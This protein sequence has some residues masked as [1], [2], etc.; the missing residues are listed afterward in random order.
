MIN[1]H[2]SNRL[3]CLF[4][5]LCDIIETFPDDPLQPEVIVVQNLGMARWLSQQIALQTGIAA[6]FDFP[7]PASFVWQ[8]FESQVDTPET[9]PVFE[10]PVMLWR[11]LELL[12]VL[13]REQ[14]FDEVAG[15]L[16][17]DRDGRKAFHLASRISDLFDQYLVFRPDMLLSWEKGQG[18][19]WQA[20]LW[21]RLSSAAGLHRAR[22][23][24]L[25]RNMRQR[26]ELKS[27][28]LPR[29]VCFFG[30]SSLAPVYLEIIEAVS[31]LT[32][33]HLLHLS[34]C[35]HYWADLTS[36]EKMAKK[37]ADWRRRRID[38]VSEYFEAGHPLLA[39]LGVV[40]QEFFQQLGELELQD[41]ALY[42]LPSGSSLLAGLQADILDLVDRTTEGGEP[43]PLDPGDRSIQ[44]HVCH[45]PLREVE[46][47]HDRLLD[48]FST[49]AGL[50]PADILVMAP[51]IETYGPAVS[52]VFGAAGE[53]RRIPWSLADRSFLAEQPLAD[54]FLSL[55]TLSAGRFSTPEVLSF[56]ETPAVLRR[57]G[58]DTEGLA[59]I[60]TWVRESGICWGLNKT[61]R[62]ELGIE[63]TEHHAWSFGL[64][65]LLLGYIAGTEADLYQG[66]APGPSV[67][68]SEAS[69]LGSLAEFLS[70]LRG[71]HAGLKGDREA[72]EWG[73]LLL[74]LLDDF[75][76]SG[77]IEDDQASLL[78]LREICMDL[79]KHSQ[80]AGF[81]GKLS[82]AVIQDLF[83]QALTGPPGGQAFLSGRV[84]FCNMVP[85]RSLPF[86]VIC[87]L[88][89]NDTDYPRNQR[90][91]T[92]DLMAESPQ[93]G[94][95]NRRNDDRYLF[96]EALLSARDVLYISWVGRD[97]HDNGVRP[98]SVV[99]SELQD[100]IDRAFIVE[101][102]PVC[103]CLSVEHPLQPFS[104]RCFDGSPETASYAAEWLP[105][106]GPS[107]EPLFMSRSLSELDDE[108]CLVDIRGLV[109][110][111]S[112]PVRF[113]LQERLG[114]KTWE[115]DDA[116]PEH[117]PFLVDALQRYHLGQDV[118]AA[119]LEGRTD[120]E[121]FQR[122][123]AGGVLPHGGFGVNF[124]HELFE[125][126][127]DLAARLI[128]IL[129][130]PVATLEI[131]VQ[132]EDFHLI[133]WL[134]GLYAGGCVR[135]RAAKLK[136]KDLLALWLRHLVLNLLAPG[137]CELKSCH[138]ATDAT[139]RLRPV[140]DPGTPLRHLLDLYR[141]GLC[142][143]LCFYP[144]TSRAW[145]EAVL[146]E[147]GGN[148]AAAERCWNSGYNYNGE[149]EDPAYRLV[150][151]GRQ[152][153]EDPFA[154]LAE[155]VYGPLFDHLEKG[156]ADL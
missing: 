94:D 37:R 138:V 50:K 96:L 134:D 14:R 29:R 26:D 135:Y 78:R 150:L 19:G 119:R 116:L 2:Q 36:K 89:M 57:F 5:R 17:D 141:Q 40:G 93:I 56:L 62:R 156:D 46:A 100:Y 123:R 1:L 12:P 47:L 148:R 39:S 76:D 146:K 83:E 151:R 131:D 20:E 69:V 108:W 15:Y 144:E 60:R 110:F 54:A 71:W 101:S 53:E 38:D 18:I 55:L 124:V 121:L 120:D 58:L 147:K 6:N 125:V 61:H 113:F 152:P 133:G 68:G 66:I 86:R 77:G 8:V 16:R 27:S 30:I 112:H 114:L 137:D 105:G 142:G 51:D 34:P 126:S 59:R 28:T 49:C 44:F 74:L 9:D 154:E 64:D 153:L 140:D 136:G 73:E 103:R 130:K 85:M 90:P 52:A 82:P 79:V 67:S 122:M 33:V 48:L 72:G 4:T 91:L 106:A 107:S 84:T 11:I 81:S 155:G 104:P 24:R 111:W 22:L 95:R 75:F 149:G 127:A 88:G 128:P 3:E 143:P 115:E 31:A 63:M 10:R 139:V 35:R 92:F 70:R 21:R 132:L 109:R 98:P 23:L 7:L 145:H 102:G 97:Q 42:R 32:E 45:S 118:V 65:R 99:V 117:E 80:Q 129:D 25:F 87:L 41:E 43:L 13:S